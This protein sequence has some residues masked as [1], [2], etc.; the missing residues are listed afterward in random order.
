MGF[1]P[2]T[3][4]VYTKEL[5]DRGY[6]KYEMKPVSELRKAAEESR[7]RFDNFDFN[8]GETYSQMS[9]R[10]VEYFNQIIKKNNNKTILFVTHS[11]P[12][13]T[14][15]FKLLKRKKEG[16]FSERLKL[17]PKNGFISIFE[18]CFCYMFLFIRLNG[19]H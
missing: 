18:N 7:V 11:D 15:L 10:V 6:G 17:L 3:K 19:S 8:G 2:Q 12:I 16:D 9:K 5:I 13:V 14:I 4:V 1:H